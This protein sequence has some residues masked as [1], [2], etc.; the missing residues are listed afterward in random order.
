MQILNHFAK[1]Y[2]KIDITSFVLNPNEMDMITITGGCNNCMGIVFD[3]E[4]LMLDY[5]RFSSFRIKSGNLGFGGK[6]W[7]GKIMGCGINRHFLAKYFIE[8][9]DNPYALYNAIW[10]ITGKPN[11]PIEELT[12]FPPIHVDKAR[13]REK[14]F[15]FLLSQAQKGD[16]IFSSTRNSNISSAIRKLDKG[17]FSHVAPYIGGDK[18]ID[19]G[20]AGAHINNLC[21]SEE[22]S[23]IALYRSKIEVSEDTQDRITEDLKKYVGYHS[24]PYLKVFLV[25]LNKK[26]RTPFF[27]IPTVSD[28]L[29]ANILKLICYA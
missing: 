17:Q 22:Y 10:A 11:L 20:P 25:Y 2:Q 8:N 28:L 7:F 12:Q 16:T 23:R 18:V 15:D 3:N 14:D 6:L 21:F 19:I 9:N 13:D 1:K 29:Y 24:Y 4:A 5:D 26:F 27:K